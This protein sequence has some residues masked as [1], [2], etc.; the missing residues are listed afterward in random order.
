[1]KKR[2][3]LVWVLWSMLI[4]LGAQA[5]QVPVRD[6]TLR[7]GGKTSF[8]AI[9][10]KVVKFGGYTTPECKLAV[11]LDG[12]YFYLKAMHS[13]CWKGVNKNGI[14]IICNSSKSVCKTRRELINYIT[15]GTSITASHKSQRSSISNHKYRPKNMIGSNRCRGTF[16]QAILDTQ[17]RGAANKKKISRIEWRGGCDS[18][19]MHGYGTLL[20]KPRGGSNIDYF[21][22]SGIMNHG[23]FVDS[24]QFSFSKGSKITKRKQ[25]HIK[26]S[27]YNDYTRYETSGGYNKNGSLHRSSRS[28]GAGEALAVGAMIGLGKWL[29]SGGGGYSSSSSNGR[30]NSYDRGSISICSISAPAPVEST[31]CSGAKTASGKYANI[32]LRRSGAGITS[33]NCYDLSIYSGSNIALGNTCSGINGDWS[34]NLNGKTGYAKGVNAAIVWLLE[35][36]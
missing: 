7:S 26:L 27:S 16:P 17:I 13:T 31:E 25:Q 19:W 28:N 4:V 21:Y 10:A 33:K 34:V 18:G 6:L 2:V 3:L 36:M 5:R 12:Q 15:N 8:G 1:M 23:F 24:V 30:G 35:R 29:F 22:L 9:Q 32:Y 14:K 11:S 20:F